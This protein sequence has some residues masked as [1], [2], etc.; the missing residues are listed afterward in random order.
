MAQLS[1]PVT[2]TKAIS[3][4][5]TIDWQNAMV[6]EYKS[7]LQNKTWVLVEKSSNHS[8]ISIKWLFQQK[9]NANSTL[10]CFKARLVARGFIQQ[11]GLDYNEIY[12]P[13]IK[14]TSL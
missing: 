7:L 3:S 13:I 8:I 11:A 14:I 6:V 9:Y 2:V 1:D 4:L 5:E 10:E 12:S